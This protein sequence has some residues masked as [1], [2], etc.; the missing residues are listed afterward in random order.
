VGTTYRKFI[1]N[2]V[3]AFATGN[4]MT[5]AHYPPSSSDL[6][7]SSFLLFGEMKDMLRGR[8]FDDADQLLKPIN[9]G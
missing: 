4:A 8:S 1:A 6:V 2:R 9:E 7:P 3:D 5:R